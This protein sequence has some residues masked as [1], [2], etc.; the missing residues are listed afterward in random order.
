MAGNVVLVGSSDGYLYAFGAAKIVEE[1]VLTDWE[2]RFLTGNKVWSTPAAEDG[3]VYFGSLDHKVYA[4][5]LADGSKMWEFPTGGAI[6]AAPVVAKGKVYIGAFDGVFYAIDAATGEEVWRFEGAGNWYWGGAVAAGDTIYAPSLDGSVYALSMD[7]GAPR[8]ILETEG[9]IVGSPVVVFDMIV[10]P[11][12]DGKIRLARLKDGTSLDACNIGEE[13]RTP[14]VERDGF[15]YFAALDGSI[16]ALRIKATGNPD[17]EWVHFT[18]QDD[19]LPRDRA[20]S[21]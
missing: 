20:P 19:P 14:L 16:R 11:S 9:L 3:V 13:V 12:T 5:S 18:D 17:E 1:R 6:A 7:S 8:W 15:V 2:W 4:V 21:C 10:V